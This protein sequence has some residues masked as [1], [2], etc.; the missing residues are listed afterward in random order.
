[1]LP[2]VLRTRCSNSEAAFT[3]RRRQRLSHL[4]PRAAMRVRKLADLPVSRKG[5]DVSARALVAVGV[6]GDGTSGA[7]GRSGVN[8][9]LL[10][11]AAVHQLHPS[12]LNL[13]HRK[14]T[15]QTR[16]FLR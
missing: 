7:G 14:N 5:G 8:G 4:C 13:A 9:L 6:S 11:G 16:L 10:T 12:I 2:N 1:M 3:C 15:R